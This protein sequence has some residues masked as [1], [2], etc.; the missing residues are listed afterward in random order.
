[1]NDNIKRIIESIVPFLVIGVAVSLLIGLFIMFSY[2]LV[3]GL[4]IGGLL[5]VATLIKNAL[6]PPPKVKQDTP[7]GRI[8]EHKDQD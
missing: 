5:W 8:I 6:F 1:M 7:Q 2:V 4:F 3:W